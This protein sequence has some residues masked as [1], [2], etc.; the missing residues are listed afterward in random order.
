MA[1][2]SRISWL[3]AVWVKF[4]FSQAVRYFSCHTP[5]QFSGTALPQRISWEISVEWV[6]RKRK[7]VIERLFNGCMIMYVLVV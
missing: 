6:K 4:D 5:F 3:L 1:K 2:Y 7:M